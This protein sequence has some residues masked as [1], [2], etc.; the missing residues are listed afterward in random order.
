MYNIDNTFLS[1]FFYLER[2]KLEWKKEGK[3]SDKKEKRR[4][5]SKR[6]G[7]VRR[8]KEG[9]IYEDGEKKHPLVVFISN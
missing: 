3:R 9:D 8:T 4:E 7:I 2:G 6:Q 5:H 1:I